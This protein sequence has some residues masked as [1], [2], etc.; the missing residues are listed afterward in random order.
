[1]IR[2]VRRHTRDSFQKFNTFAAIDFETADYGRDSACAVAVVIADG[3]RVLKRAYH[4]IR[5][6]RRDFVFTY[7]HGITWRAVAGKPTFRELW[8]MLQPLFDGVDFIAAHNASFDRAV[9]HACC[10]SYGHKLPVLQF[11]CT[12]KLARRLWSIYPTKL[13]NVCRRLGLTL[14]HHNAKSDALAC[15]KIVL[16]AGNEGLPVSAFLR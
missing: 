11:L 5:P 12:M 9:L 3:R 7:L 1:M 15:A 10:T 16:L 6:P 2:P 13:P 14:K 8:P 4:L